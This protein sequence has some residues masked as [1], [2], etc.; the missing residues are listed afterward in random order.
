[1]IHAE[2][3]QKYRGETFSHYKEITSKLLRKHNVGMVFVSSA[4]FSL[5]VFHFCSRTVN[6][7]EAS[8][9]VQLEV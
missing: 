8:T 3:L 2:I 9:V 5:T 7:K 1:M 4:I 6:Q